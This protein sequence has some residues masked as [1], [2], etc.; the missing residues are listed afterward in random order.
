[1]S[2]LHLS[3]FYYIG[4]NLFFVY[5][6]MIIALDLETTGIDPKNDKILEVALIKFDENTFEILDTYSTL[7]HPGIPI[8]EIISNITNIFDEDVKQAPFFDD[9]QKQ[10]IEDFIQDFP[11]LWHNTNF[12][13]DFLLQ[14]GVDIKENIVLDT[15]VLANIIFPYEKSLNLWNLCESFWIVLADAH[16][17]LDDTKATIALFQIITQKFLDLSS[18]KK[19][20]LN[21]IFSQTPIQAF[22]FY[23]HLFGFSKEILDEEK[24]IK[25]ILKTIGK[26]TSK[27]K[28]KIFFEK[29]VTND[30]IQEI[31]LSLP[32]SELRENQLQMSYKIREV[33]FENKKIA[34]EAPTGVGKTFAYLI[35]SLLKSLKHDEQVVISTNTKALQDQIYYKDLQFLEQNFPYTFQYSKLKWR[36]NYL[37]VLRY[38]EFI[39]DRGGFQVE[40]IWFLAKVSLWLFDTKLW[41]LDELNFYP[42]EQYYVKNIHSD[43]FLV[44]FE[45]NEYKQYEYIFK[46]RNHALTAQ[47]VIINHSL[48]IQDKASSQ[49][50]FGHIQN[51]IIDEWHNIEDTLTDA[52]IKSFSLQSLEDSIHHVEN[53]LKKQNF[54]IDNI[55]KKLE[56]FFLQVSFLF[57][58]F[59]HYAQKQNTFGNEVFQTL[60]Q[61]DFFTQQENIQNLCQTIEVQYI[62]I[63]NHLQTSPDKVF[64]SLKTEIWNL[65]EM[66]QIMKICTTKE[67]SET[68]IPIFSIQ[69][70]G[71]NI[72]Y[73]TVLN[74]GKFLQS[75]LWES[76]HRVAITSA[77]LQINNSF[78]Y[79][80]NA[81][82]LDDFDFL[83]LQSD[84]D[85]S[86]QALLFIPNDLGSIKYNNPKINEFILSFLTLTKG[87]T[88]VLLTSF[89]AIRD[90][91]LTLNLPLKKLWTTILAQ[92]V[93]WSKHKIANHFKK[94]S[95]TSVILGTDSFWE[96]VDIPGDDL[97][98]LFIH[99]FPFLVPT[100]P[101]FKARGQLYKDAFLEY[102]I[103]K[104]IIKTRQWFG[105]LIR[106]KQDTGIVILLDDR[107]FS[108]S[109]GW[110]MRASFP[111][112][113]KI[114]IGSSANFL[115]LLKTKF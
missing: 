26:Y 102:S 107:Y 15:F 7:V 46:A 62:E 19:D 98:Y 6:K 88:L 110:L 22:S 106:T 65:E 68:Y 103:P 109:W 38:F 101:I 10:K 48:L 112:D 49:P 28:Q 85:Y 17:A 78:Q 79:I 76:V 32:N 47:I 89:N 91:Y 11:I 23:K 35:P 94:H 37:S 111:E 4:D 59:F 105:R 92:W 9:I 55:D 67:S 33:L 25:K 80:K 21:F 54:P 114:K 93:W 5:E 90:L 71:N 30:L 61:G 8:P 18:D 100:D 50:I 29:E 42:H 63:F 27:E 2:S 58:L 75:I 87:K 108:T 1:M 52:M 57:D 41:E 39:L 40:E 113:I 72:L 60:I 45:S 51:L 66:V 13:R 53:T 70:N 86:T 14:N 81:L 20:I 97:R 31:F 84:F 36:K 16:R 95:A 34:I 82:H 99:K 77:T 64:Q 44:L 96:G 73:Y 56:N 104:A 83:S 115:E 24:F 69:K 43:H 12:D 3:F 74:P